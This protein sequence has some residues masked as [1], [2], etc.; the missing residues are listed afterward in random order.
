VCTHPIDPIGI[1]FLRCAHGI[2]HIG[3]H[4]AIHDTFVAITQ[5]VGFHMGQEQLHAF[6]STTLNSLS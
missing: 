2:K 5:N 6:P 4:D 3:T 1:H